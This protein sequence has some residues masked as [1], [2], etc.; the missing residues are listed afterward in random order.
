M[1]DMLLINKPGFAVL[2]TIIL[3][4]FTSCIDK[5][6]PKRKGPPIETITAESKLAIPINIDLSALEK[7][8]VADLDHPLAQ[9]KTDRIDVNI[10]ATE[11]ISEEELVKELLKPYKPGYWKKVWKT[12]YRT[13]RKSYGCWLNPFKWGTCWKDVLEEV[14]TSVDVWVEPQEA[15]YR[16][17]SKPTAKLIDKV[18]KT[19][20]WINYKVFLEDFN[21]DY[22]NNQLIV[23]A[24]FKTKLS[25]DYEQ[26]AVPLGPKIKLKGALTCTL[27]SNTRINA[28][29]SITDDIK[30][31]I[32][33]PDDGSIEFTKICFPGEVE[34]FDM[35]SYLKPTNYLIM[36]QLD[37]LIDAKLTDAIK[38]E[39]A[40]SES[41]LDFKKDVKEAIVNIS[42]DKEISD[43]L[44]LNVNPKRV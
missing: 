27:E 39:L 24:N 8:I 11:Q 22:I 33:I 34:A 12:S 5:K 19:G 29:V 16:Y 37:Q 6:P 17:V 23:K 32:D 40:D 1:N 25:L 38:K 10:L 4:T 7:S 18:Y 44:W 21:L 30:L 14:K 13:V 15:V 28:N 26:A 42:A 31:S 3:L 36:D 9:D 2:L 35:V 20:G 41:D 43:K